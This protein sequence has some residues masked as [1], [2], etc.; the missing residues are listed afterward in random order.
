M[1]FLKIIQWLYNNQ[2]YSV[3]KNYSIM[4]G[5]SCSLATGL[6]IYMICKYCLLVNSFYLI[7][8]VE[9][10]KSKILIFYEYYFAYIYV[11]VPH[12]AEV[13]RGFRSPI[14]GDA[15]GCEQP[16]ECWELNRDSLEKQQM[17]IA[18]P[19]SHLFHE[20]E[21]TIFHLLSSCFWWHV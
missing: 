8:L 6:F 14:A 3:F 18:Q 1:S 9:F 10:L 2:K 13:R 16:W 12:P 5:L 4:W 11:C 21:V 19:W 17:I 20:A 7:I 15:D